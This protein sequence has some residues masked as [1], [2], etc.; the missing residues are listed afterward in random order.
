ML[1]F[2]RPGSE[3]VTVDCELLVPNLLAVG[4][5]YGLEQDWRHGMWQGELVVQA[6]RR[7][8]REIDPALL[9]FC[10][11][12]HLARF[13]ITGSDAVGTGLFEVAVIGPHRQYGFTGFV[14]THPARSDKC[15]TEDR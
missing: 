4:T 12:D 2:H 14:D 10:P 5:G 6:L 15:A 7:D 8:V 3:V 9:L 1:T 11:T 13:R